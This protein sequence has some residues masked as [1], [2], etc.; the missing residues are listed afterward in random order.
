MSGLYANYISRIDNNSHI[1]LLITA[2][3]SATLRFLFRIFFLTSGQNLL[4]MQDLIPLTTYDY[5]IRSLGSSFLKEDKPINTPRLVGLLFAQPNSFTK[6]E[7]LS[8]IDYFNYRS[9]KTIDFFCVGYHP[10][11][12][13]SNFPV[14][15][16][17]NNVQWSF[18]PKIFNDLR[19]HF[20]KTTNWKYSGSVELI[21][22]NS[23]FDENEKTVKLDFSD[24]LA[25]DLKKAQEDKLITSVGEVFEKIFNIAESIKTDNPSREMSLKIIG[26]TGKKSIVSILFNLLPKSIQN[27]AKRVYLYGTSDYSKQPCPQ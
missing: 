2:Y 13:G 17:V 21:L 15:T 1:P 27:E 14:I 25:I 9:G 12:Y 23:Y 24:V 7:I 20:E 26:D 6:E 8:G 3:N 11:I 4:P 10:H 22:F 18:A 19:Q 5:L 16:T